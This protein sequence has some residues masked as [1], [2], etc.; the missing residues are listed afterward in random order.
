[1]S[2]PAALRPP[3]LRRWLSCYLALAASLF[4]GLLPTS[5]AYAD[6][7]PSE[8]EAMIDEQWE[9][10]E[11]TIEQYNKVRSQLK[12]NEKKAKELQKRIEPLTIQVN[13]VMADV[14]EMA[15]RY[16]KKG[17]S[18]DFTALL[19]TGSPSTLAEQLALLNRVSRHQQAQ[20]E[21]VSAARDK[22]AAEKAKLDELIAQQRKQEAELAAR[23][24]Q[25]DAEIKRL[26]AMLPPTTVKVQGCPTVTGQF[27][28][29]AR[30]AIQVAC[31][32]VGKP[33]V[34]GAAGPNA[35]DCSG[36]LQYAWAKAGVYL[37]HYTGA[38]WN[39]GRRISAS[40]ARPGDSVFFYSDLHHVGMYL[41]NGLMVHAPRTGKP[42]QVAS[43]SSMPVAGYV[44]V[45]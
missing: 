17:S 24:K 32:Q 2:K 38:Q 22:Y 18:S 42:V 12:A 44:R 33:Y 36:L 39:E 43:V 16:Y 6:P 10:L 41:G 27:S 20:I 40:E 21:A 29:K 9:Q 11:P 13:M 34:W 37:T 3:A 4:L 26:Q 28:E 31:E 7:S 23:K 14:G 45:A 30:I 35:F 15:S 8:I 19:T 1:V 5:P 25:I